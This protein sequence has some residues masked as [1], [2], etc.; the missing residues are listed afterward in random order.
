VATLCQA[1]VAIVAVEVSESV[2]R[3][4]PRCETTRNPLAATS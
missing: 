3:L 1:P 4:D 2:S